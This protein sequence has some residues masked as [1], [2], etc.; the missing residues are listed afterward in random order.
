MWGRANRQRHVRVIARISMNRS[1][2]SGKLRAHCAGCGT[3]LFFAPSR[4]KHC[5]FDPCSPQESREPPR[6]EPTSDVARRESRR[7]TR[8]GD[9]SR[10]CGDTARPATRPSRPRLAPCPWA[11]ALASTFTR[12]PAV[13]Q[14]DLFQLPQSTFLRADR[15]CARVLARG[16]SGG[17]GRLR[18]PR[19]SD[20]PGC[21]CQ[22]CHV[23]RLG[24]VCV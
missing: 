19:G 18:V 6:A 7:P 20:G 10:N 1:S 23:A 16:G 13:A 22:R 4:V 12:H 24:L 2:R 21:A 3:R 8:R 5:H 11:W 15:T 17:S 14:S 9:E